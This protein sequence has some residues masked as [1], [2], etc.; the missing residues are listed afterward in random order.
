M[1]EVVEQVNTT[2]DELIKN[3][4][5]SFSSLITEDGLIISSRSLQREEGGDDVSVNFAAISASLLTMAERGIEIINNN[6]I[7]EQIKIDAGLDD[8]LDGDFTVLITRVMAN[9]LL[10]VVYPKK[11][12]LGLIQ[13]EVNNTIKQIKK[14]IESDASRELFTS[15]GSLL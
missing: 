11:I 3:T 12:N 13:F 4:G 5:I 8:S 15:I 9:V 2:L 6:K 7:L 1:S 14:I 10:Q